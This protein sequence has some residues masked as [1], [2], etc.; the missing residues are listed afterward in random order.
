MMSPPTSES[1][2]PVWKTASTE[3]CPPSLLL[4]ALGDAR[5]RRPDAGGEPARPRDG[6]RARARLL[7]RGQDTRPS[8]ALGPSESDDDDAQCGT[9]VA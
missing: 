2:W 5:R 1:S 9:V 6:R 8:R 4:R 7:G 3:Q